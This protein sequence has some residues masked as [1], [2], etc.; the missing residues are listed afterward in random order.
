M[1]ARQEW[2]NQD[3]GD[4]VSAQVIVECKNNAQPVALFARRP[5]VGELNSSRI[6]IGGFPRLSLD[7]ESRI[8]VPLSNLLGM[9]EWH[10][11]CRADKVATQFSSALEAAHAVLSTART[12]K[13]Q[14]NGRRSRWRT[15]RSRS[16]ALQWKLPQI[17]VVSLTSTGFK[18]KYPFN[19]CLYITRQCLTA[20]WF[21][22][23]SML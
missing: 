14:R 8:W 12:H 1:G 18:C 3:G 19:I 11:Y 13:N 6:Q 10:H 2:V 22:S 17:R 16:L 23:R 9:H 4:S 21:T 15:G 20:R 5:Q 7:Q